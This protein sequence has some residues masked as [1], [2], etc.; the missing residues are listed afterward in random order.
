MLRRR[1]LALPDVGARQLDQFF[2]PP[3]AAPSVNF[4]QVQALTRYRKPKSPDIGAKQPDQVFVPPVIQPVNLGFELTQVPVWRKRLQALDIGAKQLDQFFAPPAP[5]PFT[6]T[7]FTNASIVLKSRRL[8]PTKGRSEFAIFPRWINLLNLGQIEALTRHKWF[9]SPDIGVTRAEQFF[10]P[11][12]PIT[13][14]IT[15]TEA[16]DTL[17]ATASITAVGNVTVTEANDSLTA[18]A[19]ISVAGNIIIIEGADSLTATAAIVVPPPVEGFYVTEDGVTFYVDESGLNFYITEFGPAP[20]TA[21][22]E[23]YV[24]NLLMRKDDKTVN[25]GANQFPVAPGFG[26]GV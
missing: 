24:D 25:I 17:T 10:A 22:N 26:R 4:E 5:V 16:N 19:L 14:S 7:D 11:P 12:A 8:T 23:F 18:A 2:A 1:R 13:G 6:F 15:A 21:L 9:K 20:V 3:A